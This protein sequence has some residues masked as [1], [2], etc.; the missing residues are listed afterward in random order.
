[1]SLVLTPLEVDVEVAG[2]AVVA[3]SPPLAGWAFFESSGASAEVVFGWFCRESCSSGCSK[4]PRSKDMVM[5]SV[6]AWISLV[7]LDLDWYVIVL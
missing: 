3:V 6:C 4:R 1:M 2:V 5:V 7:A